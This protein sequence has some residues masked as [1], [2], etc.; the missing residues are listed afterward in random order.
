MKKKLG[1]ILVNAGAVTLADIESALGDQSAGEPARLG[2]LLLAAGKIT[3][4][5][6]GW[7]LAQQA[8][9][10]YVELPPLPRAV[11]ELVPLALQ[12]RY[13]FVPLRCDG[14]EL[15]IAMADLANA[16]VIAILE[17]QWTKV[18]VSVAGGDEVDQAIASAAAMLGVAPPHELPRVA[19]PIAPR[20]PAQAAPSF[21]LDEQALVAVAPPMDQGAP[22]PP[23]GLR[24]SPA[25]PRVEDLFG[26]L[27]LE[28][29]R[30]GIAAQ[31]PEATALEV[32]V[33]MGGASPAAS[34]PPV[35]EAG[36]DDALVVGD[37]LASEEP[38]P[39]EAIAAEEDLP[40]LVP[41]GTGP[42]IEGVHEVS[43]KVIDVGSAPDF[44]IHELVPSGAVPP[45][46]EST[47]APPAAVAPHLPALTAL[48]DWLG[49]GAPVQLS[50]PS[51]SVPPSAGWT[52]ALDH[53]A[54][55]KLVQGVTRVLLAKGLLTEQEILAALGQKK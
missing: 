6:L 51:G 14:T 39:H 30:T 20:Q 23:E 38:S 55:S 35:V 45:I 29:A 24:R 1:E 5:Q 8:G 36:A 52:G 15:T 47:P 27:N 17:Q 25:S 42:V 34:A 2:E 18:H 41:E 46:S 32:G 31:S 11:L 22:L 37:F 19:P 49:G 4:A 48:P 50:A 16:E 21:E 13:R 43:G 3:S 44:P 9:V 33:S 10:P 54:P 40:E 26:D 12:Q 28:S 7:A 53:L